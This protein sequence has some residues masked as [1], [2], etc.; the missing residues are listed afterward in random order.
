MRNLFG[1]TAAASGGTAPTE[2]IST[3]QGFG[4][5]ANAAGTAVFNNSMRR[6]DNNDTFRNSMDADR[7]WLKVSEATYEMGNTTLVGFSEVT[8]EEEDAGY[9]TRRLATVVSLFSHLQDGT[10]EFGIQALGAFQT[11]AKIKRNYLSFC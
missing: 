2:F 4:F 1:G 10:K 9:D 7:I 6:T 11:S 3:G 8:S 5:K